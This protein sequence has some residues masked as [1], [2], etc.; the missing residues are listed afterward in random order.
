M[1]P[2][3]VRAGYTVKLLLKLR[4]ESLGD[5]QQGRTRCTGMIYNPFHTRGDFYVK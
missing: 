5:S 3:M 2:G 4:D 1:C